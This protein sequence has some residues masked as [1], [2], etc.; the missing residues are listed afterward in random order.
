MKAIFLP[1]ED[2]LIKHETSHWP[3]ETANFSSAKN[4]RSRF[5][6]AWSTRMDDQQSSREIKV[7]KAVGVISSKSKNIKSLYLKGRVRHVHLE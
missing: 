4:V 2:L 7:I 6:C 3:F 1:K 5:I